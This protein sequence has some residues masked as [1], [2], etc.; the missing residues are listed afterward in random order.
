LLEKELTGIKEMLRV[1]RP[2]G[3]LIIGAM[4]FIGTSLFSSK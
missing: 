1:L 4:S 2:G 3:K